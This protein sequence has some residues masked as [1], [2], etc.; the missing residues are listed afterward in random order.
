[1]PSKVERSADP[2]NMYWGIGFVESSQPK[3][4]VVFLLF[5][6]TNAARTIPTIDI[7]SHVPNF[8]RYAITISVLVTF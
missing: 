6:S 8:C 3:F 5:V 1:M 2:K 7:N 4:D